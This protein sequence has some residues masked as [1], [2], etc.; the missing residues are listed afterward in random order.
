MLRRTE[1]RVKKTLVFLLVFML[2]C[3]LA[4][5][6]LAGEQDNKAVKAVEQM[7]AEFFQ[8][9]GFVAF[10][11]QQ[12]SAV[13]QADGKG[14]VLRLELKKSREELEK[15]PLDIRPVFSG[16][17]ETFSAAGKVSGGLMLEFVWQ[18]ELLFK[19]G[20]DGL[21]DLASGEL[22]PRRNQSE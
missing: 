4:G 2:A 13:S 17:W 15:Y 22:L 6:A 18:E 20:P 11:D 10:F 7:L 3:S 9:P 16:L 8:E 14:L 21:L 5:G 12:L 19:A 1:D